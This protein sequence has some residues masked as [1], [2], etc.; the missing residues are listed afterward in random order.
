MA[1][2]S[3]SRYS[4]LLLAA[5]SERLVKLLLLLWLDKDRALLI[6]VP[7]EFMESMALLLLPSLSGA[8]ISVV[9]LR[10]A[11]DIMSVSSTE[12]Q[13]ESAPQLDGRLGKYSGHGSE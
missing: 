9:S 7:E 1:F 12:G 6:L 10:A 8:T 5:K 4:S 11:E 13:T 3:S 2:G